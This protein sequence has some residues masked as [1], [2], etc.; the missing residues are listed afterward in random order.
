MGRCK[1]QSS[2][3]LFLRYASEPSR[4]SVLSFSILIS[5]YH[6]LLMVAIVVMNWWQATFIVYQNDRQH[7]LFTEM[8]DIFFHIRKDFKLRKLEG[9]IS[10]V[11]ILINEVVTEYKFS[12]LLHQGYSRTLLVYFQLD[13]FSSCN[14]SYAMRAVEELGPRHRRR[15]WGSQVLLEQTFF[16][17]NSPLRV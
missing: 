13:S 8:S 5:P 14:V 16:S 15:H 17:T 2:L 7:A 10:E 9:R 4:A 12:N 3:K 11:V 1:S 6:G